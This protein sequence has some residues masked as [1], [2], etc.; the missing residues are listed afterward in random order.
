MT[1]AP[2]DP[3]VPTGP[4]GA[5]PAP[6]RRWLLRL[7]VSFV[8]T[9]GAVNMARPAVSYHALE[10][11]AGARAVGVITAVFALLPLVVAVPL[12]RHTDRRRC[13]PLLPVGAAL[14]AAGCALSGTASSLVTLAVWSGVLG[15]GHLVFMIGA[16]SLVARQS[17]PGEHDRNFGH[18]TIGGSAGQLIGPVLAGLI[19]GGAG[20]GAGTDGA[21]A[22]AGS[23][24]VSQHSSAVALFASG[25]LSLCSYAALWRIEGRAR[26]GS[27]AEPGNGRGKDAAP[28]TPVPVARIL[29]ARGVPAGIFA[30]LAVLSTTDVLTAY[31]PV[32][33][34]ERGIAPGMVGLLLSLRAAAS[35]LSRLALPAMTARLGRQRLLVVSCLAAGGL[36]ALLAVPVPVWALGAALVVLGF[37]LGVGQ[38]LTMTT[39]VRAAPERA[40]STALAL[41]L[42]GNRLG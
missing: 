11:G 6:P 9:Q 36:S 34:E 24:A 35:V 26:S 40:R 33:G 21:A 8:F 1:S 23:H 14:I 30:S 17:G 16:Q 27:P 42:T 38:P 28:E 2:S 37:F 39:V 31:L 5:F 13:G 19:V 10:L 18:F 32:V 41:R 7:V 3:P 25:A 15:L 12:G 22:A 20:A 29:R 4:G